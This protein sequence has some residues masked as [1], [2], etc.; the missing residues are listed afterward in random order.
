[1]PR[2]APSAPFGYSYLN[3]RG[4]WEPDHLPSWLA[5]DT[6]HPLLIL[7]DGRRVGF[8]LVNQAPSPHLTPGMEYRMS[9]FFILR[10]L[11]RGGLGKHAAFAVFD[12]FPGK[13][14][15]TEL[16]RNTGAIAF[17][18]RIIGEYTDG[19]MKRL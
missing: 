11:R 3:D 15:L 2:P 1:M 9:E 4:L 12:R 5:D 10:K 14:E 8:A 16:P 18:R 13:W 17:W 19:C 6:D 7:A